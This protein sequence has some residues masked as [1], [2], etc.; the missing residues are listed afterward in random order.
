MDKRFEEFLRNS[1]EVE[2]T[3]PKETPTNIIVIG[4][5]GYWYADYCRK[6]YNTKTV[7]ELEFAMEHELF[8]YGNT[9]IMLMYSSSELSGIMIE[10]KTLA[11][12]IRSMFELI[13][14]YTPE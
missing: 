6:H 12:G 11:D 10:S 2:K 3:K 9:I 14:K 7:A 1:L 5:S 4:E 13:W 8:T